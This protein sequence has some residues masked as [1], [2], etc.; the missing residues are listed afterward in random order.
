[1]LRSLDSL[2]ATAIHFRLTAYNEVH[3]MEIYITYRG[4][5]ITKEQWDRKVQE[6][7]DRWDG[8]LDAG[9]WMFEFNDAALEEL[10]DEAIDAEID[11]MEWLG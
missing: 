8:A 9:D 5:S 10:Y 7:N 1:V 2:G 11:Y 3:A 6:I 4:I